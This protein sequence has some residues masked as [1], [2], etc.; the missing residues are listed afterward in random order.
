MALA[1]N[2][3]GRLGLNIAQ[4]KN[5]LNTANK[6][7]SSTRAKFNKSTKAMKK[8]FKGV[9]KAVDKVKGALSFLSIASVAGFA[10]VG[11]SALAAADEINQLALTTGS[12]VEKI[13][14]L[15]IAFSQF[16]LEGD[17]VG[18]VLNTLADRSKDAIDGMQSFVDDFRLIGIEV[19]DLK[20]KKPDQLFDTFADAIAKTK[21]PISRQAAL[22]RILGDDLGRKLAP[23]LMNGA[24]GFAELAKAAKESGV[25]MDTATVK[26]AARANRQLEKL[27]SILTIGVTKSFAKLGPV[28]EVAGLKL[29]SFLNMGEQADTSIIPAL[30]KVARLVGFVADAF[31]GLRVV[32]AGMNVI[33]A[34][35]KSAGLV[36]VGAI[37]EGLNLFANGIVQLV[38]A[39]LKGLLAFVAPFSSKVRDAMK[40]LD[41]VKIDFNPITMDDFN[42]SVTEIEKAKAELHKTLMEPLPSAGIN[43]FVDDVEI[44]IAKLKEVSDVT[45]DNDNKIA[46]GAAKRSAAMAETAKNT[47]LF[48]AQLQSTLGSEL[49]R[50]LD[51]NFKNIGDSFKSMMK[52]M[53]ADAL[54]ADIMNMIGLGGKTG[55]SGGGALSGATA[56]VGG[57]FADGGRPP[58]G[59][60]SV[61]GEKGPEL[62][63]PDQ[64]G[65]IIP[66]NAM[67]GMGGQQ[68]TNNIT[69]TT[70][71]PE[72]FRSASGRV[73]AQLSSSMR[74]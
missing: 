42:D 41:S 38:V 68:V 16:K 23:A 3:E 52:K 1:F 54:A 19:D 73:A 4:F 32:V 49:S 12:S 9:A 59:R 72:A 10:V 47:Q 7:L 5:K 61:I 26:G 71:T 66:N 50:V 45:E 20:G 29:E 53:V 69:I 6:D 18:D 58:M 34:G 11:K 15:T 24:E 62:F 74:S 14:T 60:P 13:Q 33:W 64:A 27:K 67:G 22:V 2:L 37:I 46:E 39:P 48:S 65:T 70:P 25:I 43:E 28:I 30:R 17:D 56:F 35:F 63:V 44:L 36:A 40:S 8:Q 31:H 55:A 21:D 57:F 51:G